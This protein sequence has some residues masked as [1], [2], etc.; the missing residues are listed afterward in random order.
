MS[1]KAN[2]EWASIADRADSARRLVRND[3]ARLTKILTDEPT[4]NASHTWVSVRE[5]LDIR[6]SLGSA[7]ALLTQ[8]LKGNSST[9]KRGKM[10]K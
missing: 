1:S 9:T 2:P 8:G 3:Y 6:D 7:A 4:K 10:S 5:L